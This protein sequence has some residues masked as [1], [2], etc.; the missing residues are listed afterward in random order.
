M[1]MVLG[2]SKVDVRLSIN[3]DACVKQSGGDDERSKNGDERM[4]GICTRAS[5]LQ[6]SLDWLTRMT[7][8]QVCGVQLSLQVVR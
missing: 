2:F 1:L 6:V 3:K 4:K 5:Y 8:I 7:S